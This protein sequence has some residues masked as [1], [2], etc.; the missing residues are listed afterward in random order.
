MDVTENS[1]QPMFPISTAARM[2]NISVH[3][4]RMYEKEGLIIP[5]K[6]A[7]NHRLYSRADID[8]LGCIR[9]AINEFKISISGI[10]TIYSLIPCWQI[11]NCS[12]EVRQV[13]NA[14]LT[15]DNPCWTFKHKKNI[16]ENKACRECS[17]YKDY[18]ECGDVKELIKNLTALQPQA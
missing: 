13:C 17:V 10:K 6:K 5:F 4:L 12:A 9:K 3:T 15:H 11:M 18:A 8:R 2:L 14:F 1:E 16:C 7:T